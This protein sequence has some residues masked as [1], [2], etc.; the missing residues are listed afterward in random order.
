MDLEIWPAPLA[1]VYVS[2]DDDAV[3]AKQ[4][5]SH[6][7]QDGIVVSSCQLPGCIPTQGIRMLCEERALFGDKLWNGRWGETEGV[8]PWLLMFE[9]DIISGE[10]TGA[11][12]SSLEP[13][14]SEGNFGAY[15]P[16]DCCR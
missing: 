9:V 15:P 7:H 2:F 8:T 5:L 4:P 11:L 12:R 3:A 6:Q 1:L 10:S 13:G 16:I 14:A